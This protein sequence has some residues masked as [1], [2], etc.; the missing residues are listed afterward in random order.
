MY[1]MI[2]LN[3]KDIDALKKHF[4]ILISNWLKDYTFTRDVQVEVCRVK[5]EDILQQHGVTSVD[6]NGLAAKYNDNLFKWE[7]LIFS[8]VLHLCPRDSVFHSSISHIKKLFLKEIVNAENHEDAEANENKLFPSAIDAYLCVS[9]KNSDIGCFDLFA[10]HS[11]FAAMIGKSDKVLSQANLENRESAIKK[12]KVPIR[13]SLDF[14]EISFENLLKMELGSVF[15]SDIPLENQFSVDVC[16]TR[17][18][19]ASMGKKSD[20]LAFLLKGKSA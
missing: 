18:A 16:D 7:N 20:N 8:E 1:A 13:F 4:D 12:I 6:K 5:R 2:F 11:Y 10:S 14:G 19:A 3:D 15:I 17:I 9:I